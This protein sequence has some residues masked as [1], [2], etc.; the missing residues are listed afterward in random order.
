MGE[1]LSRDELRRRTQQDRAAGRTV[2]FAS[3][4]FD[5]LRVGHVRYLESAA[6]EADVLVVAVSDDAVGARAERRGAAS[7]EGRRTAP[8]SSRRCGASTTW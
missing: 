7:H 3:G 6:R 4:A 1:V 2:A 8:S 5:L